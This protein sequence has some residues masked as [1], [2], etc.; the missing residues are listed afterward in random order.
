MDT[1]FF[2]S[3]I[4]N[5]RSAPDCGLILSAR[6]PSLDVRTWRLYTGGPHNA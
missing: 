6:E 1:L 4:E 2:I 3:S 5:S